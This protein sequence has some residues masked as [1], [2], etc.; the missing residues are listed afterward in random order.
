MWSWSAGISVILYLYLVQEQAL[1]EARRG[2]SH[3]GH[4]HHHIGHSHHGHHHSHHWRGI[5]GSRSFHSFGSSSIPSS[6]SSYGGSSYG[7]GGVLGLLDLLGGAVFGHR[8][9]TYY[10]QS[11][12]SNQQPYY[13]RQS[14]GCEVQQYY[15]MVGMQQQYYCVCN[16]VATYQY[17]GCTNYGYG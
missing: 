3:G 14:T 17:G 11:Y 16:G 13:Y 1:V 15:G 6:S 8:Q 7:G 5:G 9:P 10:S 4:H 2:G 12:Y